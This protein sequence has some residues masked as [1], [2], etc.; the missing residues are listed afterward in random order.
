[1]PY[2][3]VLINDNAHFMDESER[4][5]HGV[6]ADADEAIAAGAQG[7]DRRARQ[8]AIRAAGVDVNRDNQLAFRLSHN[9]R[10]VSG[11][12]AAIGHLHHPCLGIRRRSSR[13]L[14][15]G[16]FLLV[17]FLPA[18]S[19]SLQFPHALLSRRDTGLALARRP[20]LRRASHLVAR[21]RISFELRTNSNYSEREND[22]SALT[23]HLP[24]DGG[25]KKPRS[26]PGLR[27]V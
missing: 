2:Y 3:R 23:S 5:D 19:L 16:H 6:F 7:L 12:E 15:P 1:M 13:L 14:L 26:M 22:P 25:T 10:V 24:D 9:L 21:A 4:T 20:F 27:F 17:R 8:A 11:T 18:S